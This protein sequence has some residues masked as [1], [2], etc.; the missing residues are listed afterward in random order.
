MDRKVRERETGEV[1]G[2]GPRIGSGF[3]QANL[4]NP[5]L[6]RSKRVEA[7]VETGRGPD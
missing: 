1:L 4:G 5:A 6:A 7:T 3:G 2:S